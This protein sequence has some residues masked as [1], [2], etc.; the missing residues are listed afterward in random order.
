MPDAVCHEIEIDYS[1]KQFR[2]LD[3]SLS[4]YYLSVFAGYIKV[5]ACVGYI[6]LI[7]PLQESVSRNKKKNRFVLPNTGIVIFYCI[8]AQ[9][10]QI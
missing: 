6:F 10:S 7:P 1:V 5:E 3:M 2:L 8:I 9:I 4:F